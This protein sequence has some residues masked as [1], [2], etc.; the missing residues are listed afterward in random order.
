MHKNIWVILGVLLLQAC[1]QQ[2]EKV[3]EVTPNTIRTETPQVAVDTVS[4]DF[5]PEHIRRS[6]IEVVPHY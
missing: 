6:H 4:D 2:A 5:V 1:S 3:T